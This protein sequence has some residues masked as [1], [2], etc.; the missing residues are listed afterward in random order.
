[1]LWPNGLFQLNFGSSEANKAG[2]NLGVFGEFIIL[3]NVSCTTTIHNNCT[4]L[5]IWGETHMNGTYHMVA[6]QHL[7]WLL[8]E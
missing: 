3:E 1:L 5:L 7:C 8:Y 2:K 6:I 4:T